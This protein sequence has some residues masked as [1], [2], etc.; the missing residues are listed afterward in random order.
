M[1]Q[2]LRSERHLKLL[3]VLL[4]PY[5]SL[6]FYNL[7]FCHHNCIY[8]DFLLLIYSVHMTSISCP[9]WERDPS[10][11]ALPEVSYMFSLLKVF[12]GEFSLIRFEGLRTE[13][14]A[15]NCYL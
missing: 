8:C 7:H 11:V 9:S 14:K 3:N 12:I 5:S 4:D 1:D 15:P 13:G 2:V 6:M 10:S